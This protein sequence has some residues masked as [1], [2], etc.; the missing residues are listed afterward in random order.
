MEGTP[1]SS[2]V[3]YEGF[4]GSAAVGRLS[5]PASK[6]ENRDLLDVLCNVTVPRKDVARCFSFRS[7]EGYLVLKEPR[8]SQKLYTLG[9]V[10][11]PHPI[12]L[13]KYGFGENT[14]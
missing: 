4:E 10:H 12:F 1:A 13:N 11:G 3:L 7:N 2:T 9:K 8:R 5:L 14:R 6:H